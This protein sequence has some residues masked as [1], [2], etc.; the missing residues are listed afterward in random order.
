MCQCREAGCRQLAYRGLER[1]TVLFQQVHIQAAPLVS[2]FV[3][4]GSGQHVE[5]PSQPRWAL[6]VP[7][8][9]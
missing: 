4:D 1:A 2:R 3:W 6:R 8:V 5:D 7:L 9:P